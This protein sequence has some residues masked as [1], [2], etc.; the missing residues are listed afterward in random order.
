MNELNDNL[1]IPDLCFFSFL[2][3][4]C[5]SLGLG[6]FLLSWKLHLLYEVLNGCI[7]AEKMPR[8]AL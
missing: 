2:T 3:V 1:E 5:P 7:R 4:L 6:F 8:E